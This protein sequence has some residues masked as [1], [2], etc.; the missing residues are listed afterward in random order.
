MFAL[1]AK[2]ESSASAETAYKMKENLILID[3][4][5]RLT[6]LLCGNMIKR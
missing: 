6:S 2:G 4:V 3:D 5:A 1:T